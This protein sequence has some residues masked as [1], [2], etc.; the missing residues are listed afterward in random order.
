MSFRSF[1]MNMLTVTPSAITGLIQ[2]FVV[3]WIVKQKVTLTRFEAS[4]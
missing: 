3:V 1:R 2:E 4:F